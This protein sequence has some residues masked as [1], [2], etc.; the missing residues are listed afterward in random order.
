M[1]GQRKDQGDTVYI[2][3]GPQVDEDESDVEISVEIPTLVKSQSEGIS[4][5]EIEDLAKDIVNKVK[6]SNTQTPIAIT[7]HD[8][9]DD[10]DSDVSIDKGE[11][12]NEI[13]INDLVTVEN[14]FKNKKSYKKRSRSVD[15]PKRRFYACKFCDKLFGRRSD[16]IRHEQRAEKTKSCLNSRES[17]LVEISA[18][19]IQSGKLEISEKEVRSGEEGRDHETND[20]KMSTENAACVIDIPTNTTQPSIKGIFHCP[21]CPKKLKGSSN[22]YSHVRTVHE[23]FRPYTCEVCKRQFSTRTNF[24][25]HQIAVHTRKCDGCGSYV[26][27]TEPWGE[28]VMK[29][30]ERNILC[31]N[32]NKVVVFFS[33][34]KTVPL[35]M[36]VVKSTVPPYKGRT[37]KSMDEKQTYACE[38]CEKLFNHLADCRRHQQKHADGNYNMCDV[39]GRQFKHATS[40]QQ[41]QKIH[42]DSYVPSHCS[43]CVKDFEL[44]KSFKDHMVRKHGIDIDEGKDTSETMDRAVQYV[45]AGSATVD[46]FGNAVMQM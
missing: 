33:G 42:D 43:V 23:K 17:A 12:F 39:C 10:G 32:C 6:S 28:G 24:A 22:F 16:C 45:V 25:N 37:R 14:V 20:G 34:N 36:G 3:R 26:A 1:A 15:A 21:H 31:G 7:D 11:H 29:Q 13:E 19:E 40:L 27:E 46:A 5:A 41:H 18:K 2:I 9:I 30:T 8:Y 35:G 4:K 38:V 44:R